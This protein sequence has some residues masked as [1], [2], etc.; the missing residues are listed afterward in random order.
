[1]SSRS[2]RSTEPADT[3]HLESL[4][5]AKNQVDS[6]LMIAALERAGW[7]LAPDADAAA[8]LIVNTCGFIAS[9]KKESIETGLGLRA[10]F[11]G[12]RIYMVGCLSQRYSEELA[13]DMP[14]ID[15]FLGNQAPPRS[16][17]FSAR[18]PPR[19][20]RGQRAA[21]RR[22]A[23]GRAARAAGA[24]SARTCSRSPAAPT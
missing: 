21:R 4:G 2:R 18:P 9:A 11:P 8:V 10:R 17:G 12:K 13:A 7:R 15:G 20:C 23:G 1:M 24:T 14:E 16:S 5:C 22:R 3:F 19:A 6:E